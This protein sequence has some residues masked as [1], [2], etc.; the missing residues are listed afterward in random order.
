MN[1]YKGKFSIKIFSS[2]IDEATE[3]HLA[4]TEDTDERTRAFLKVQD[5]CDYTCSFCTIP[6]ARGESLSAEVEHILSEARRL[7]RDGFR[8][9]KCAGAQFATA[10][11][12][13]GP[14]C[15]VALER[16][17]VTISTSNGDNGTQSNHWSRRGD[18]VGRV[19]CE[20]A[21]A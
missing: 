19:C 20:G 2:P 7:S 18:T 16:Q 4:A 3:F 12:S 9:I 1:Y 14:D 10:V 11:L 6:M 15:A 5:G 17:T 21:V 8:E 13:P